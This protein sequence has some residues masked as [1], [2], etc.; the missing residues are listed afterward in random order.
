MGKPIPCR[1]GLHFWISTIERAERVGVYR[2]GKKCLRCGLW[3][4]SSR[5]VEY[6]EEN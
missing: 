5:V 2:V 6:E 4:K 1:L 3:H